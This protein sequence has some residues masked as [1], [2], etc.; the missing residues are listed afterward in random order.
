M[1][2]VRQCA[3]GHAVWR[4]AAPHNPRSRGGGLIELAVCDTGVGM[5]ADVASRA[6]GSRAL[7]REEYRKRTWAG[8]RLR[9]GDACPRRVSKIDSVAGEGTTVRVLLPV[10]EGSAGTSAPVNTNLLCLQ[11]QARSPGTSVLVV[12]DDAPVREAT[13]RILARRGLCGDLRGERRTGA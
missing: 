10:A 5:D 12:E 11:A 6:H 1:N 8:D 2:L 7:P 13:R 3:S 4:H 9:R